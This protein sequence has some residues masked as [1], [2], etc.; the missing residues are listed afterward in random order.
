MKQEP[1]KF[2]KISCLNKF[3]IREASKPIA[4][5]ANILVSLPVESGEKINKLFNISPFN[6]RN[7]VIKKILLPSN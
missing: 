5:Y 6:I 3:G 1:R 2:K 4:W 7:L